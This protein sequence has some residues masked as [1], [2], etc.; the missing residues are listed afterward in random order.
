[1]KKLSAHRRAVDPLRDLPVRS[2]RLGSGLNAVANANFDNVSVE[3]IF[4]P[5]PSALALCLLGTAGL[6]TR[7][8]RRRLS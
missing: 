3:T 5:E 7:P 8:W 4:T 6:V 1:M 2:E